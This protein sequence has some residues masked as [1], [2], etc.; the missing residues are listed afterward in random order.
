MGLL[1][2]I[3]SEFNINGSITLESEYHNGKILEKFKKIYKNNIEIPLTKSI[4]LKSIFIVHN[5]F[6]KKIKSPIIIPIKN[7]SSKRTKP[8]QNLY[9]K[10][11][12]SNNV[13]NEIKDK[14]EL[15]KTNSVYYN[16]RNSISDRLQL[17]FDDKKY[18]EIN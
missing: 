3:C 5:N 15:I 14:K 10:Y 13:I 2:G 18:I 11:K 17:K 6:F 16:V 7:I 4:K 8:T 1:N 9:D 12:N